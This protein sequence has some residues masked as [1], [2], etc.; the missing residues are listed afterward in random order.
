MADMTLDAK[1]LACP[2]PIV[3]MTKALKE[4]AS[5]DKLTVLADDPGFEPDVQAW[6]EAQ[7]HSIVSLSEADG[8]FT[9]VI[10]IA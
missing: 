5:G 1:G 7:G 6:A 3:K 10:Q 4:L 8:I 2:M 9:A